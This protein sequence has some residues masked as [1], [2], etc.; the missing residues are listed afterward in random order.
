M[1]KA[2]NVPG[3]RLELYYLARAWAAYYWGPYYHWR[4]LNRVHWDEAMQVTR[5]LQTQELDPE[6]RWK[7]AF[8]DVNLLAHRGDGRAVLAAVNQR[9]LPDQTWRELSLRLDFAAVGSALGKHRLGNQGINLARRLK[10]SCPARRDAGAI[11][12]MLAAMH[13]AAKDHLGAAG[14]YLKIVEACPWPIRRYAFFTSAMSHLRAAR[15][16]AYVPEMERYVRKI[17]RVQEKVPEL[18]YQLG[19]YYLGARNRGALQVL[20]D[21]ISRYPASA[22]R[23][24]LAGEIAK[25]AKR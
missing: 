13:A 15:S 20:Q 23:D 4:D 16:P 1:T 19:Y 9:I 21:L 8:A 10:K 24:R 22:V 2:E 6:L 17:S 5:T 3:M 25:R 14:H 7:M 12:L 11:E 18:M